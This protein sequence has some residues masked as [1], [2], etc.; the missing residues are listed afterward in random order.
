M[1]E[2]FDQEQVTERYQAALA[3]FVN[4][5]K[6]DPNVIAV[7]LLGGLAY[8]KVWD[9]SDIDLV[10]MV[11]DQKQGTK[12]YCIDEDN[13]V[14]NVIVIPRTDFWELMGKVRG[15]QFFH[16]LH[17]RSKVVYTIDDSVAEY[18][19]DIQ[20]LGADDIELAF[21]EKA[22]EL[23]GNMEKIE[24]WLVVK[25]NPMYAQ[26]YV[27]RCSTILA[28]MRLLLEKEPP[29]RES[30]LRVME[31][32][33]DFIAPFYE[34]PMTGKMT[35]EEIYKTLEAMRQFLRNNVELI[36]RPAIRFMEDGEIKTV[37]MLSNHFGIDF[38]TIY[39]VFEFLTE[40]GIME[41]VTESIRITPKGKK[42]VE[43]VAFIYTGN[44]MV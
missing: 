5:V 8:D 36:S 38:H 19:A 1:K 2:I 44:L 15:G 11:R 7:I 12:N 23:I 43:E 27:L 40:M 6:Q 3:A 16:S 24:K 21:F 33:R 30:V 10:V 9:K 37:T 20:H 35:K 32:D 14:L 41:K 29:N 25:N 34:R 17:A 22:G 42:L 28:D 39:H 26:F 31:L 13:I 4:K 18:L